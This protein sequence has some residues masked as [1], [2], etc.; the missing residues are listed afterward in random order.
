MLRSGGVRL[1]V[2]LEPGPLSRAALAAFLPELVE[3][4]PRL[5]WVRAESVHV[6]LAFLGE[7]DSARVPDIV[8]A[9]ESVARAATP[10]SVGIRGGGSFGSPRAPR[11]LWLGLTGDVD[12]L[13]ALQQRTSQA[14]AALG[15]PPEARRFSPH[16]TVAR[17]RAP[18]GDPALALA[19]EQARTATS[20]VEP[21]GEIVLFRSEP[22]SGGPRYSALARIPLGESETGA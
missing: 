11:I 17:A 18:G 20:D 10:V 7:V 12:A 13:L 9:L 15:F 2:A 22:G 4:S 14:L 19:Q 1:F 21:I 8:G 5:R 16:L 3:A 6:T